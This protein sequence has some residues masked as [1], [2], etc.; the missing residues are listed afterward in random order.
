MHLKKWW[1]DQEERSGKKIT[2]KKLAERFGVKDGS[3]VRRWML[4]AHH[5]DFNFP[6][7]D[8]IL[9]IQ[10]ATLGTVTARDWYIWLEETKTVSGAEEFHNAKS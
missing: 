10:E 6:E 5:K 7:P 8:N 9:N 3:I 1:K 4:D 2:L